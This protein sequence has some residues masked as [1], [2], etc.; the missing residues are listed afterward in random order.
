MEGYKC[1]FNDAIVTVWSAPNY[2]G[3]CGNT[4]SMLHLDE[5]LEP[6]FTKFDEAPRDEDYDKKMAVRKKVIPEY[7]L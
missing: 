4:A 6:Q 3:R 1:M 7:F 5:S 2:T